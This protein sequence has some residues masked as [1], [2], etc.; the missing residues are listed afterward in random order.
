[1]HPELQIQEIHLLHLSRNA[2]LLPT[3]L[4][5]PQKDSGQMPV[6]FSMF[7]YFDWLV[8]Q[9]GNSL[10][11]MSCFGLDQKTVASPPQVSSQYLTL[12]TLEDEL[13]DSGGQ[14]GW[15]I[16]DPFFYGEGMEDA[17]A[18]FPFL[19]IMIVTI[20]P[21][22][23]QLPQAGQ[24]SAQYRK[25]ADVERFLKSCAH[26]LRKLVWETASGVDE[27]CPDTLKAVFQVYHCINSGNFCIAMRTRTPEPSYHIA[28]RVRATTLNED[29]LYG[30]PAVDCSTFSLMGSVYHTREDGTVETP[31]LS[32]SSKS[33][34][35]VALR[36]SVTNHVRNLLFQRTK[37]AVVE[38]LNGLYGRY[39]VTLHLKLNQYWEL[40]PWICAHK[41]GIHFPP[42]NVPAA[43]EEEGGPVTLLKQAME[44]HGAQYIN[45]RLLINLDNCIAPDNNG[46]RRKKRQDHVKME[47]QAIDQKMHEVLQLADRL[48][49][50]QQEFKKCVCLLQDLWESYSSLRYQ[51]DSFISGNMLLTQIS[52]LLDVVCAYI[53]SID[54]SFNEEMLYN[55]LVGSL[56]SAINSISHFQKLMLSINQQS[57]QAP[58]YEVQIHTDMEKFVVAYTEFSRRFLAEHFPPKEAH[59]S[60]GELK[61]HRQLIFPIIT[62]DMVREAIQAVPLFL[63]PYH[64]AVDLDLLT[65]NTSQ[66]RILLSIE[67]PDNDAFGNLYATLPLICH[68]LFHN[69][70]VLD[71]DKRNDALARFLLYRVAQYIV[72]RWIDQAHEDAVY[73]CFGDLEDDLLVSTLAE[74][75]EE[76]YRQQCGATHETAN[77]GVLISNILIFLDRD[78]FILRDQNAFQQPVNV[79]GQIRENLRQLCELS[80]SVSNKQL[81]DWWGQYQAC[82]KFLEKLDGEEHDAIVKAQNLAVKEIEDKNKLRM[83][84]Q[85]LLSELMSDILGK[86]VERV[87]EIGQ[88]FLIQFSNLEMQ[89]TELGHTSQKVEIA[90]LLFDIYKL[91]ANVR[92]KNYTPSITDSQIRSIYGIRL[93]LSQILRTFFKKCHENLPHLAEKEIRDLN[94]VWRA[95]DYAICDLCCV[96]KDADHLF[97]LLRGSISDESR[98]HRG[99]CDDL[100]KQYHNR[101]R[102]ELEQYYQDQD[103][104]ERILHSASQMQELLAPLGCDLEQEKLFTQGLKRVLISCSE[105][106]L[107]NLVNDSTVLYREIFADLGMCVALDL[108]CFGYLRVLARNNVFCEG[109]RDSKS[110]TLKR[111]RMLLVAQILLERESAVQDSG[112][113]FRGLQ[114]DCL[115]CFQLVTKLVDR[116]A[117]SEG[118]AS[119]SWI[120][121]KEQMA[122]LISQKTR[123][124]TVPAFPVTIEEFNRWAG[125]T[126]KKEEIPELY[127]Q[128]Q[129]MWNLAHLFSCLAK[130]LEYNENH[131]LKGHFR[132]L[133]ERITEQWH[134]ENHERSESHM[135]ERVG[136]TYNDPYRVNAPV[137]DHELFKDTLSFVLYYYY[138]SWNLYEQGVPTGTGLDILMGGAAN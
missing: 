26:E 108:K 89:L 84:L 113:D 112:Y 105:Q 60:V 126:E 67:M 24:E 73:A 20:S 15:M 130:V 47:N 104:P 2:P 8:V 121:L 52:M 70:R 97:L 117:V 94:L 119:S 109:C 36:L 18:E 17:F 111:E 69:F 49:Y 132:E 136:N 61:K 34:S 68:E 71:R 133:A 54:P 10:D 23:D 82:L 6:S 43:G 5:D 21:C 33:Q 29:A 58:N 27:E 99:I 103:K 138:H 101:L 91:T 115:C 14:S 127:Q 25:E 74:Q 122:D 79:P 32:V 137:R 100:L 39:D 13:E 7:D 55:D 81:P 96:I 77:I 30:F 118:S 31:P 59:G 65:S 114:K 66:E 75:L 40:Y 53:N 41:L 116:A 92:L 124:T 46:E 19:S 110:A 98:V 64:G 129:S 42:N 102:M 37:G 95:T 50:C 88:S 76:A 134:M 85:P 48:P 9:K 35:K 123:T 62:V 72:Q 1:M 87:S 38:E 51:D 125:S 45:A 120:R 135:L 16:G 56:R 11:H 83:L 93:K 107:N 90:A 22:P 106:D 3:T 78:V 57:I 80:M 4:S 12:V 86:Y 128:L 131:K 28:M 63:L 44:E